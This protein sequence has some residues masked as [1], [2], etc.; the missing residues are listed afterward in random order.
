MNYSDIL[1]PLIRRA[2][3]IMLSAHDIEADGNVSDKMGDAA[4]MVTVYDVA[5]QNFLI[6][7][8]T[9]AIPDAYFIAEEKESGGSGVMRSMPC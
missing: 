4:N 9:K 1:I 8:I 5:V 3:E 7:E 6:T 2:G